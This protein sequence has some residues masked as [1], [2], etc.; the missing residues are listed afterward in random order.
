MVPLK[1]GYFEIPRTLGLYPRPVEEQW[2]ICH[3]EEEQD[4]VPS[5]RL[6]AFDEKGSIHGGKS[7]QGG[8]GHAANTHVV[9]I[10][11]SPLTFTE[12]KVENHVSCTRTDP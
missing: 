6:G 11:V 2:G 10:H 8:T 7:I 12:E 5:S 4:L 9:D 1:T 3:H